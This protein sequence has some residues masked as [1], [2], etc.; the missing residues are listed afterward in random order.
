MTDQTLVAES[1]GTAWRGKYSQR[2]KLSR[3]TTFPATIRPPA[4]VRIYHRATGYFLLQFWDPAAKKTLYG[5][6]DGDLLDAI[7]QAR[8]IERNLTTRKSSGQGL[9]QFGHTELVQRYT[10]DLERRADAG[11][12][13]WATP[14]RFRAALR[15]YQDYAKLPHVTCRYRAVN[16]VDRN[17]ALGF[18]THLA[19]QTVTANG[20][21][22]GSR[23]PM[24][25]QEFVLY[26][27]RAM[28]RWAA[29]PQRGHC[30]P[31][32]FIHPF[33][34]RLLGR[35]APQPL[36]LGDPAIT[37]TMAAYFLAA[38]DAHQR[39]LFSTLILFGL[40]AAE[41]IFLFGEFVSDEWLSVPCVRDLDYQTKGR[42]D[43]RLPL[44]RE[45][46]ELLGTAKGL[47]F[48]RRA[49]PGGDSP[50]WGAALPELAAEYRR[51]CAQASNLTALA[52]SRIRRQLMHDAGALNYK[53]IQSEFVRIARRL[54][55]PQGV[56]L[57]D[58]R[59]LFATALANAGVPEQE[60]QILMGH[61]PSGAAITHY[62]HLN[63]LRE[64]F[65][66]ALEEEM[67]PVLLVLRDCAAPGGKQPIPDRN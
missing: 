53:H 58:F 66:R 23:R 47:L 37:A 19:N 65:C 21:A 33:A 1:L 56:T 54:G 67:R 59:H 60:R 31:P 63:R 51:R 41:P 38:C 28:F 4:K 8:T 40:R 39:R 27:V 6:V 24:R 45:M 35:K 62:T 32:E 43:K 15:H 52:K 5:R 30:L 16:A 14:R 11:E 29:D 42:R 10:A 2:H 26:A 20:R 55:W 44:P 34:V 12:L 7:A 46:R 57:K 25:G 13:A 17:F 64:H 9:G 61:A 36:L 50:L 18:A 49:V 22:G 48:T 3:V